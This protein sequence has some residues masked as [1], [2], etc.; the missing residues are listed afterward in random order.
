MEDL[1]IEVSGPVGTVTLDRAEKKNRLSRAII[2]GLLAACRQLAD[3]EEV[4]VVVFRASGSDF[5]TGV[6]L[7]DPG[8]IEM[9]QAPMGRRRRLLQIGPR[10]VH[11]IQDLPQTTIVAMQGYCLG[12]AGCIALACDL[13]VAAADLKFGMPEVRRGMNMSWHSVPLMVAHFGPART[14]DLLLTGKLLDAETA[15]SWGL[16]N[17]LSAAG[18]EAVHAEAATWAGEL[19][20]TLPPIQAS[21]IKQTVNAVANAC[22][23]MVH[24]DSDQFILAQMTEDFHEA[25]RAFLEKRPGRY[26]GR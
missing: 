24:M 26:K 16:A 21:M 6:D 25:T 17:R 8:M 3:D 19:A 10:V 13:R 2:E 1:L 15:A 9:A 7:T 12:G 14:K 4:R 18:P 22:T 23:P 11:A 5:S 20:Q